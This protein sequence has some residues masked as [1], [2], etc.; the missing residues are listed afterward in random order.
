MLIFVLKEAID[1]SK[2]LTLNPPADD[3]AD[4]G[5][6]IGRCISEMDQSLERMRRDQAEIEESEARTRAILAEV[7][8]EL[9]I[10]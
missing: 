8:A 4:L 10:A 5:A 9:R 6:A 7:Q 3:A 1:M 2:T